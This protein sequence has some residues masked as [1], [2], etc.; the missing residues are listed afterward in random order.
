MAPGIER[1]DRGFIL[2]LRMG[3]DLN[4]R[5]GILEIRPRHRIERPG[6]NRQRAID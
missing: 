3:T 4:H 2:P 6:R 1:N 5:V